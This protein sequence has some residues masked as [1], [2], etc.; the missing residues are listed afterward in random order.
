MSY[1]WGEM[2]VGSI[3][4]KNTSLG[5][6]GEFTDSYQPN[7]TLPVVVLEPLV[8]G[9]AAEFF[10]AMEIAASLTPLRTTAEVYSVQKQWW[11]NSV[12]HSGTCV[13]SNVELS[14]LHTAWLRSFNS[15]S[16]QT[17]F[18]IIPYRLVKSS[19][20][21]VRHLLHSGI[22]LRQRRLLGWLATQS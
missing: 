21:T 8:Y 5:S 13:H 10:L 19:A 6:P 17:Q 18:T 3:S 12:I 2:V 4:Q 15:Q 11:D 20:A 22:P 16:S 14:T 1:P 7:K 9:P